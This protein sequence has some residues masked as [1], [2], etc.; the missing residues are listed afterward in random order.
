M[1][2]GKMDKHTEGL[3]E[4]SKSATECLAPEIAVAHWLALSK[5]YKD[6]GNSQLSLTCERAAE[7]IRIEINTGVAVCSCCRKPYGRGNGLVV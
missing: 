6:L 4:M 1:G 3:D 2:N 7:S 5:H